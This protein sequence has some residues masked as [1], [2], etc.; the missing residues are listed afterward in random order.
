MVREGGAAL[1]AEG[2]ATAGRACGFDDVDFGAATF[3]DRVSGRAAA[4]ETGFDV[5]LAD[6]A[7]AFCLLMSGLVWLNK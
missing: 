2:G 1:R 6:P 4:L 5:R 3:A 7:F